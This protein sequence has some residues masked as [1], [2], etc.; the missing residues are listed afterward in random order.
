MDSDQLQGKINERIPLS[1]RP[2]WAD[3]KPVPQDDGPN[4]VV[5]ISYSD[6]FTETMNYFRAVYL[7][8][9]RSA[10]A[11]QLTAEA[12]SF[13][14]HSSNVHYSFFFFGIEMSLFFFFYVVYRGFCF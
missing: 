5:P 6:K 3:V 1:Q 13:H 2:D 12:V 9:E 7:A 8:D 11:L 4:P 14:F 10:R